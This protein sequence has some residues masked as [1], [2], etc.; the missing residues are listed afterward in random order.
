MNAR[1]HALAY[2]RAQAR[3][4]P[5]IRRRPGEVFGELVFTER[6]MRNYLSKDVFDALRESIAERRTLPRSLAG[7]AANAIKAWAME[8]GATHFT[9]WF[10]PLTGRT[11]EKHDSFLELVEGEAMERFSGD[12]LVQQEPDASSFPSGGLRSTFEARGYTA[13][14]CSSPIFIFENDYGKTLCIPTIFVSYTGQALDFK[15]PLLRS[16]AML[17]EAATAVA[18]YFDESVQRVGVSMGAE[19]EYFLIDLG[20]FQQ[21]PDLVM[22]GRTVMGAAPPRGQQLDD[23]YFGTIPERAFAFMNELEQECHKL[24]IPL[25][26]RHNEVAPSQ[27]ECAPQH[28]PLNVAVDHGLILMDLI[29]RVARKHHL[30]ALMHEKPFAGINGSGKHN[31]WSMITDTGKNLL[32]PGPTPDENLMFLAF[33]VCVIRA[34]HQHA[35]LLWASIASAG[36]DHRLGAHEAPPAILSVF[37]GSRLSKVLDDIETPPRRKK[38]EDVSELMHLGIAEIPE[39]LLDNTDRNRTSPFAFT[40]NKFEFR[41]V[42]ALANSSSPMT[43]LNVMVAEQLQYFRRRVDSKMRRGREQEAALLDMIRELIVESKAIRFEGDGYSE[44]WLREAQKRRLPHVRHTPEALDA[45]LSEA[46]QRLLVDTGILSKPEIGARYEVL[47]QN[48]LSQLRIE[49]DV[50]SEMLLT[51]VLPTT[52]RYQQHLMENLQLAQSLDLPASATAGQRQLIERLGERVGTIFTLE[53]RLQQAREQADEARNTRAQ[54]GAY[55]EQVRPLC[56]QLRVIADEL[57]RLLPDDQW[58]L[59]KYR[60]M[61]FLN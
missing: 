18:Q 33:F 24:G 16:M 53:S 31:N 22:T 59:P 46:A 27:F 43:M 4:E 37:V 12:E 38:N 21:R 7:P 44:E 3:I 40:G 19:Q 23:H 30:A 58:P 51:Q 14:D 61:L 25:R 41:A 15:I 26:T 8:R 52:T 32:S 47:L 35:A 60:E 54:A 55:A 20:L 5:V 29:G 9:H 17:D 36:N 45:Y 39:L 49:A 57:E 56:D 42:G 34:I 13:W 1:H 50:L 10:Q 6:M 28:E 48:Y 2:L 11:A